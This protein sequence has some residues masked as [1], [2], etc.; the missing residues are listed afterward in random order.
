[1]EAAAQSMDIDLPEP[2]PRRN[3][4]TQDIPEH[5]F[6]LPPI[7]D[8]IIE[9]TDLTRIGRRHS[10]GKLHIP[11]NNVCLHQDFKLQQLEVLSVTNPT[12]AARILLSRKDVSAR[13]VADGLAV[14]RCQQITANHTLLNHEVNG[15]CYIMMSV[16]VGDQLWFVLPGTTD[17][18]ESSPT[19]PCPYPIRTNTIPAQR[20][21]PPN[22]RINTAAKTFLFNPPG[23]FFSTIDSSEMAP[24]PYSARLQQNQQEISNRLSKRESSKIRGSPKEHYPEGPSVSQQ[25]IR[26]HHQQTHRRGREL[27]TLDPTLGPLDS[28][29]NPRR[30]YSDRKLHHI[31]QAL[32]STASD[33]YRILSTLR[34]CK[35]LRSTVTE[36]IP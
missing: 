20:V 5:P 33:D 26:E 29:S 31:P 2:I 23:T 35:E 34:G 30:T 24:G 6:V 21:L 18:I 10:S 22:M 13:R 15:T 8:L 16:L 28:C 25:F 7:P 11:P 4:G 14:T 17:L 12:W 9:D 3:Q 27:Q 36:H 19:I 32:P 1:M